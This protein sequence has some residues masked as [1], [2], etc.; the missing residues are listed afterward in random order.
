[1]ADASYPDVTRPTPAPLSTPP[2]EGPSHVMDLRGFLQWARLQELLPA[3]VHAGVETVQELQL[4]YEDIRELAPEAFRAEMA[5]TFGCKR[6]EISRLVA[7]LE[8]FAR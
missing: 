5:E 3:L 6:I 4:Y 2:L 8:R 7:A 1:M